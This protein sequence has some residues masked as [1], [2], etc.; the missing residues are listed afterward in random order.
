MKRREFLG[1]LTGAALATG[2][3][4]RAAEDIAGHVD[5]AN[6]EVWRRFVDRRFDT[7]LHYAGPKGEVV[8]PTAEE[9]VQNQ[10]NGMSW[11][12]PTEDGPFFGGL[13]LAGLC[14]RWQARRDSETADQARRIAA[15]LM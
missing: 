13:Y 1:T 7:V 4:A 6:A 14:R 9:C 15:G 10:P 3:V 2:V 5:R 12:T 8:L 11:S